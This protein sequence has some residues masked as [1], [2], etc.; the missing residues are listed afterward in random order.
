MQNSVTKHIGIGLLKS[1]DFSDFHFLLNM[2]FLTC[3]EPTSVFKKHFFH[4]WGLWTA[5]RHTRSIKIHHSSNQNCVVPQ[6]EV[7]RNLVKNWVLKGSPRTEK[8]SIKDPQGHFGRFLM[9]PPWENFPCNPCNCHPPAI[10]RKRDPK[11][12]WKSWPL[13]SIN[14]R[15]CQGELQRWGVKLGHGGEKSPETY[16]PSNLTCPQKRDYFRRESSSN[17]WQIF[18]GHVSFQRSRT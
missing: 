4:S 15:R 11:W 5:T 6:R 18:R 12:E 3:L 2:D 16:T 17:H 10:L 7:G 8:K 1:S 14:Q 9:N 13:K